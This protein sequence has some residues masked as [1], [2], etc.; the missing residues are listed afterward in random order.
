MGVWTVQM[1]L[2]REL[3]VARSGM[4]PTPVILTKVG[5]LVK[6]DHDAFNLSMFVTPSLSVEMGATRAYFALR[7]PAA[8]QPPA[9]TSV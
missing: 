4:G 7:I 3:T 2:M 1:D 9:L 8:L 6:M 5:S